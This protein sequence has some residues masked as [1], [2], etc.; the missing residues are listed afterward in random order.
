MSDSTKTLIILENN[1]E[2]QFEKPIRLLDLLNANKISINQS[3]GGFGICTTCRVFVLNGLS[4]FS[5]RSDLE[6]ERAEE[7]GFESHERLC[8]QTIIFDD[9][10]I[11]IPTE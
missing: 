11:E 1:I 3:C 10:E 6:Q 2:L 7:R 9:A 8:C 4:S 5:A